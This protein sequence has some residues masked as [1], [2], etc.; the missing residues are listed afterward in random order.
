MAQGIHA[1]LNNCPRLTHLSLTGVQAFLRD[2]LL[3]YCREAPPEFNEHQRD[4][5]CVFSGVGVQ[6]LRA[7]LNTNSQHGDPDLPLNN[8]E[9]TMYH[10][11]EDGDGVVTAVTAQAHVMAIDEHENDMDEDDGD[12]SEMAG[13]E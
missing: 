12:D 1:L 5:F 3:V 11:A 7:F 6:R 4:V 2:D 8:H 13:Q 9:G 10:E